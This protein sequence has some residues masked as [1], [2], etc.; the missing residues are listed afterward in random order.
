MKIKLEGTAET[1]FYVFLGVFLAFG[2]NV[3]LGQALS[4]GMPVVAVESN[5][6]VPTFYQGDILIIH[7]ARNPSDYT[8]M[9]KIGDIIVFS[10]DGREIP[11]VHRIIEINPDNS[12][13][14]KGDASTGQHSFEKHIN[15]DQIHGKVVT[16]IP[17]LGW[18]KIGVTG[19]MVPFVFDNT[20]IVI[21]FIISNIVLFVTIVV[22]L[23]GAYLYIFRSHKIGKI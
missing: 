13:Q 16:I 7:G 19:Y 17:Y 5:S 12:Y 23:A 1:L 22:I 6:M 18:V 3:V 21:E 10:V 20:I 14:T 15:P 11:I 2:I 9:L 8:D 4:T